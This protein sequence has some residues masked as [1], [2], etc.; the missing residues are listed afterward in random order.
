MPAKSKS[1]EPSP[2]PNPFVDLPHAPGP[3]EIRKAL[4]RSAAAWDALRDRISEHFG[5][6]TE[7]WAVPAKKYGWSLRLK[8]KKRTIL[9]LGPRSKHFT[10]AVILGEKAVA[11]L[12]ESELGPEVIAMVEDST[13]YTEGRVIRFEIR[14]MKQTEVRVALA[15]VKMDN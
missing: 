2:S 5:P 6:V 8:H 4:G 11:A 7:E 10:A 15:K 13:K 12:R 1:R 3:A 9:H 14:S